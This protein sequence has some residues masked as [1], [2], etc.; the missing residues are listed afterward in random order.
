M[1][2]QE[3]TETIDALTIPGKGILA[4]DESL[5]TIGKRFTSIQLEN[6]EEHRRQYRQLL[7]T[8]PNLSEFINGVIL[9]EETLGQH[10]DQG[11]PLPQLLAEQDI[12]PGIKVDKGLINLPNTVGEKIT[13]G[14]DGLSERL[15]Q[16]KEQGARFAKWRNVYQI[17]DLTPS[18]I[19]VKTGAHNLA[20]YAA[21]C[22]ESGIVPIVE[23]E[24]LMD[25]DHTIEHC[26]QVTE[27]VLFELFAALFLHQ[28]QLELIVLKPSMV[29]AGADYQQPS[30]P[31]EVAE[32][33][34]SVFRN[35]V[36]AAVPTINFLSG[37]Q[38]P[39][40][41]TENLNAMN[42]LGPHPWL[43]SFSYGRALQ[44]PCLQAWQG[45]SA[46]ISAA[47]TALYQ[48]AQLNGLASMGEYKEPAAA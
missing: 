2:Q 21:A 5:N 1:I 39:Q 43:L 28:V 31:E 20:R 38:T 45:Q 34:V 14:L 35:N 24:I 18:L 11:K 40:Q 25:G 37:G 33:T 48:R 6:T 47:Q 46:N 32:Y 42:Q 12:V 13:Q 9:F 3:L 30:T 27:I 4:A 41:A 17:S 10:D 15:I 44:E 16:Y 19:A 7:C 22:Q 36:P 26:A 8:T 29:I 23:P